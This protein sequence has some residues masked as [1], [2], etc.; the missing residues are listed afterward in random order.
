MHLLLFN[1]ERERSQQRLG[2]PLVLSARRF[3]QRDRARQSTPPGSCS[4]VK[5]V[6]PE[7]HSDKANA[8]I[9]DYRKGIH[10]LIAPEFLPIEITNVLTRAERR[11]LIT[12]GQAEQ[13]LNDS[14]LPVH[15]FQ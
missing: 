9:D 10:D 14:F 12:I 5:L 1:S 13:K 8:L 7:V 11:K 15:Q 4:A 3:H 6:L 2:V